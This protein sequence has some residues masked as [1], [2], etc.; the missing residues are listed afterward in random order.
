MECLPVLASS[1]N[2]IA[3]SGVNSDGMSTTVQP[4]ASAG[5]TFLVIMAAGKFQ[6]VMTAT[7]PT[8]CL[9]TNNRLLACVAGI[10]FPYTRFPSSAYHDKI[11]LHR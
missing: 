10:V 4:T 2:L 11:R 6:G 9:E 8:G 1:T 7:T 3:V 5:A